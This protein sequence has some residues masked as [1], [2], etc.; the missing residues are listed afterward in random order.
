[1]YYSWT[2][3]VR[4]G[5]FI[6]YSFLCVL[7]NIKCKL[8][9]EICGICSPDLIRPCLSSCLTNF[10]LT[11]WNFLQLG[12]LFPRSPWTWVPEFWAWL[13]Q[14]LCPAETFTRSISPV[15]SKCYILEL[16]FWV[17]QTSWPFFRSILMLTLCSTG[18]LICP[19]LP[20]SG[21]LQDTLLLKFYCNIHNMF[22]F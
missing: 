20:S 8:L 18:L 22:A 6:L 2:L 1:M 16:Y 12:V 7:H 13:P 17:R 10:D 21:D 11:P 3:G 5:A 14:L 15:P 4:Q 9:S 19:H